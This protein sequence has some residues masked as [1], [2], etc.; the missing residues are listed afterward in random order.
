MKLIVNELAQFLFKVIV[1]SG[2][3]PDHF[4]PSVEQVRD[5]LTGYLESGAFQNSSAYIGRAC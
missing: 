5:S 3:Q 1:L 2:F 4:W